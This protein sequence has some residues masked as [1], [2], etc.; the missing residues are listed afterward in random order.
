[1][2]DRELLTP[3]VRNLLTLIEERTGLDMRRRGTSDIQV[4]FSNLAGD[5]P[6]ALLRQLKTDPLITDEW[7]TII[8]AVTIGESYFMRDRT[9]FKLLR[10]QI[11]PH[12]VNARRKAGNF[13]LR[14]WSAGCSSGEEPYSI[15]ITL[16]EALPD[17]DRWEIVLVGSD[18]SG[19]ALT[20]AREGLYRAWSFRHTPQDFEQQYFERQDDMLRIQ[21]H[22]RRMVSFVQGSIFTSPPMRDF[23]I[24]FCR[25]VLLYFTP[26]QIRQAEER[27]YSTLAPGGWLL[28]GPA[29]ALRHERERWVMHLFPGNPVYQRPTDERKSHTPR[30]YDESTVRSTRIFNNSGEPEPYDAAVKA[31]HQD[32]LSAA[33]HHLAAALA[34]QPRHAESHVLLAMILAGRAAL[35]E[36]RAHLNAALRADP[37]MA[38]AHYVTALV[39][40]EQEN[41]AGAIKAL[42]AALYCQRNHAL[43]AYALGILY[44]GRGEI[45]LAKRTWRNAQRALEEKVNGDFVSPLSDISVLA[46]SAMVDDQI[47][48]L[49][50]VD[51][52]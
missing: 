49:G 45:K 32:Q 17:I 51:E 18:I 11:L 46:L 29:E 23:D 8:E 44:R 36:A 2:T 42:H 24:V 47:K 35:P 39:E 25:N 19:R 31:I 50:M 4:L 7:Q 28:L 5:N 16:L 9:H 20:T 21:P 1:M 37:L 34:L 48:Q 26:E 14:I 10:R 41:E 13:S 30:D 15:A 3:Y 43:A 12:L 33:E 6:E 52:E 40:L 27:L 22:I 38:D